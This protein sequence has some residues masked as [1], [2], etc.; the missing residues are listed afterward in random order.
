[1][2]EIFTIDPITRVT[3]WLFVSKSF[4]KLET[5]A[6]GPTISRGTNS[7]NFE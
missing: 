7:N 3:K 6:L 4:F 1:M 5:F 2:I